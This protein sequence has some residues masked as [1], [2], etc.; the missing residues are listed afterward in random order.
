VVGFV[1]TQVD[2]NDWAEVWVLGF[3]S[4]SGA[5]LR[6]LLLHKAAQHSDCIDPPFETACCGLLCACASLAA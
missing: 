4:V 3:V 6:L 5:A 1:W 2:I